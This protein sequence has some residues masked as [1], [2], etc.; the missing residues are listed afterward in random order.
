MAALQVHLLLIASLLSS[1][2]AGQ[3]LV[4]DAALLSYMDQRFLALERLEKCN[5]DVLEY[6]EEFREFSKAVLSRLSGL[7]SGRAELQRQVEGLLTRVEHAQRDIDYFGSTADSNACVEVHEELLEQQLLEEEEE[8]KRLKLMFNASCDHVLAGIRSLKVVKKTG[9]K[10]G[11]WMKD[12]GKKHAKIYLLSGSVNNVILEF[13]N[14]MAFMEDNQSLKAR[15]VP[16]PLPWEGTGHVVYQGFLF[17]HRHGS[18]N[19][20]IKFDI[21]RR[22]VAG[23]MLLPGAGRIPA[24][25]LSAHTKIDLAVD[26]QGL[27]ALHAEPEAGGNIVITKLNAAALAVE[28]SW[29]T[30]CSSRG[31]EAAFM[32]CSTLHV[33]YN[34]PSGGSSRVLCVYG[35]LGARTSPGL[36]LPKRQGGHSTVHYNPKEK[37]LFAWGDGSQIIYKLHTE[38][39]V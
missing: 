36:Q 13:A 4:Q 25:Q 7:S 27:W 18:L 23:Q 24:Y 16:L 31:A 32:A 37:Q 34:S 35:V 22:K 39:K 30:P 3:C 6:V 9:A 14:I 28:H 17:Y 10:H 1:L 19:E 12:P 2:G 15:R 33:L 38:Q 11:S 8:K 20:I 5:Q 29:D 26:E 21:R